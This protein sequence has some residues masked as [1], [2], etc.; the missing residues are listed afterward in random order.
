MKKLAKKNPLATKPFRER[1]KTEKKRLIKAVKVVKEKIGALSKYDPTI[2]PEKCI[3]LA[4]EGKT[5]AQIASSFGVAI[6]TL[7]NWQKDNEA[8]AAAYDIAK[9]HQQAFDEERLDRMTDGEL[10]GNATSLIFKMKSLYRDDYAERKFVENTQN[11]IHTL[12][13]DQIDQRMNYLLNALPDEERLKILSQ[14]NGTTFEGEFV[15]EPAPLL[16]DKPSV[17]T[18]DIAHESRESES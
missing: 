15:K 2:H 10:R 8:F 18:E 3:E 17:M 16:S 11:I 5:M 1:S 14:V 7:R 12:P 4:K 13:E 9:T 6:T